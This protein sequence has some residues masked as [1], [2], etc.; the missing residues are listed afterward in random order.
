MSHRFFAPLLVSVVVVA[1]TP[2]GAL[3]QGTGSNAPSARTPWGEP[4]LQGLWTSATLTP[5][6]RPDRMADKTS[7]TDE[8]AAAMEQQTIESRRE[9]HH[10]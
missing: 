1:L 10:R 6:E 5:L 2:V 8:E 9:C 7:L 4:D 3:G